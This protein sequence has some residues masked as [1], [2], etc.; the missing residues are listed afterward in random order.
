MKWLIALLV[1]LAALAG[2]F[3]YAMLDAAAPAQ[4]EGQF[5]LAGYRALVANDA[6]E[7]LPTEVRVEFVGA[8][9]APSFATE[10]GA[11]GPESAIVY[12]AFQIVA[13]GGTT[14]LDGAVDAETAEAMG[15]GEFD[16]ASYQRVLD[17]AAQAQ[18]VLITHEHLDHVMAVARHPDPAAL[19]PR[20]LL[21][22]AQLERLPQ[23]APDGQL[24]PEIA[25]APPADF[26]TPQRIAPGVVAHATPGH[27]PGSI[28]VY[29]RTAAREY[30][31]IGDIVWMMSNI[32]TLR[33]RPRL[34]RWRLPEVD[35][36]RPAVLRQIRALHDLREANPEL[37][38]LPAHDEPYL[39]RLV[40]DGALIDGFAA[41]ALEN[42][43]STDAAAPAP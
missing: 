9:T 39:R 6:A 36:D 5:D 17:A 8:S 24:A 16:A 7:T 15:A 1:V 11:F 4:A 12:T 41:T 27:T 33:G 22:R 35:P 18:H 19:A 43:E 38:I 20:L 34:I 32:D 25:D 26:T 31:L 28:V 23:H 14:V 13:P 21:T 10:A 37:I 2:A 42:A 29:A 30:L 3:W 40:G